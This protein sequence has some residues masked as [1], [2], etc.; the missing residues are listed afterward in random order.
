[1]TS[2]APDARWM[3]VALAQADK[4]IGQTAENPPVGCVILSANG[5][6]V[7]VGHT[8]PSGRPH[9]ETQALHMAGDAA[10]GGV[11][12]VTLEPCAHQ[13]QTPPCAQA[14]IK[15]GVKVVHMAISDPDAR[16]AGQ[17]KQQLEE[18]G[19]DV[20]I[21]C[22]AEDATHQ[23]AG[24]LRRV[25]ANM[26]FVTLKMATS[27]DGF[28]TAEAQAQTWLT[29][30]VSRRYVHDLRSRHDVILT[31]MGTI[32]ADDPRLDIRLPG[33]QGPQPALAILSTAGKLPDKCACLAA[34]R[35][36]FLF[37]DESLMPPDVPAQV[38]A[39]PTS[40]HEGRVSIS[41]VLAALTM[42]G[43][44]RVMVE[45]GAQIAESALKEGV[46]DELHWLCAPHRL[47]Q[48]VLAWKTQDSVDFSAPAD[49]I[50]QKRF[51][52]TPDSLSIWRANAPATKA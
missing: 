12:Y 3:R 35:P 13:G 36:I 9:A 15:A 32:R 11:A 19:I 49:Y 28:I 1:M 34:E 33:W 26:P 17:G 50:M 52:L 25:T 8:A 14:L 45:A 2:N 7:G 42:R 38:T 30:E 47:N 48:G 41:A 6:L 27:K 18:A 39:V 44:G 51:D 29:G 40:L 5:H 46:I 20:T 4:A 31:G 37:H 24:F 16:V 23:M 43:Y 10:K 22:C 21:G